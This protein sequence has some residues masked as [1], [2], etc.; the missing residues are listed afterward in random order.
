[1]SAPLSQAPSGELRAKLVVASRLIA[2]CAEQLAELGAMNDLRALD[3][4]LSRL[5]SRLRAWQSLEI[6]VEPLPIATEQPGSTLGGTTGASAAD[7]LAVAASRE[8]YA[9]STPAA[10]VQRVTFLRAVREGR[11]YVAGPMTG[12]PGFNFATFNAKARELRALGWHVENPAEHG[13]IQGAVRSDYL[14][15]DISRIATCGAI[16]L[17]PDWEK[18]EGACLEVLIGLALGMGF[19]VDPAAR[20]VE[21][22]S[23][24]SMCSLLRLFEADLE[25]VGADADVADET[26]TEAAWISSA[27]RVY[28][29]AG[30]SEEDARRQARY[31]CREQDWH[32]FGANDPFDEALTDVEGRPG[33]E[34]A[35]P[36]EPAAAE[37]VAALRRKSRGAMAAAPEA[38]REA[39]GHGFPDWPGWCR[40][41]VEQQAYQA[42]VAD[43]RAIAA[44]HKVLAEGCRKWAHGADHTWPPGEPFGD[45]AVGEGNV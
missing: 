20:S 39:P 21:A 10:A 34:D 6:G 35:S 29:A 23:G 9:G 11:I 27:M 38:A 31:L 5:L 12:L 15:W 18:S 7:E 24:A 43:S 3:P 8:G 19:V 41:S 1:M 42:G 25:R 14:R 30:D 13:H 36:A 26:M 28:L 16:F 22:L 2:E 37:L 40:T 32:N 44:A 45:A 4:G 17:L 33:L